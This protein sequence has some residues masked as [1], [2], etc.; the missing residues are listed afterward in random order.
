[1]FDRLVKYKYYF[2]YFL[3][4]SNCYLVKHIKE[5]PWQAVK[6]AGKKH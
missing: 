2:K 5:L 3:M 6:K 1:M 4:P